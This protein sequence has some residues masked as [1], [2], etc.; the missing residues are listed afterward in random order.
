MATTFP[1]APGSVGEALLIPYL[2]SAM[3][4]V[5]ALAATPTCIDNALVAAGVH[6]V[7]PL[8]LADEIGLDTTLTRADQLYA[9]HDDPRY[10]GPSLLRRLVVEGHLGRK[11]G[12]GFFAY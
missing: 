4:M 1:P 6:P 3:R 9:E 7:G 11:A 5:E 8:T 2:L 10:L 12:R